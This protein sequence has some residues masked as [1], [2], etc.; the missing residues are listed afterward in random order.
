LPLRIIKRRSGRWNLPLRILI[1]LLCAAG[2]AMALAREMIG[3][4]KR[5]VAEE[6]LAV[7]LPL[8]GRDHERDILMM[9]GGIAESAAQ[10]ARAADCFLRP[11]GAA[12]SGVEP[13]TR[14]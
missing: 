11:A 9:L 2:A 3:S 7:L 13:R 14:R 12:G 6:M 8:A 1:A 10:R 4:G 5:G